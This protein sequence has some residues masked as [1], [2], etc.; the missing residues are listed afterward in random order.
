MPGPCGGFAGGLGAAGMGAG[1]SSAG[2]LGAAGAPGIAG[3]GCLSQSRI[4]QPPPN[5]SIHLDQPLG[6]V[7]GLRRPVLLRDQILFDR[8]VPVEIDGPVLYWTMTMLQAFGGFT[9]SS[10]SLGCAAA[11]AR[12]SPARFRL[13][14]LAV[15]H[16]VLIGHHKF[17]EPCV[18][19]R[20]LLTIRP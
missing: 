12:T 14:A 2:A 19:E 1:T 17:L 4:S 11:I 18:L 8:G 6:D 20:T 15:E 7:A 5:G 13:P 16:R 3:A 10:S 9:L